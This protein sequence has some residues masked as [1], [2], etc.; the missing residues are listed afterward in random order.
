MKLEF[1]PTPEGSYI[2][3]GW[4]NEVDGTPDS[5]KHIDLV[6]FLENMG[7]DHAE[8]S[9]T[10]GELTNDM[11]VDLG[12]K[13][14]GLGFKTLTFKRS[15]GGPATRWAVLVKT[16]GDFDYYFVDLLDQLDK[17]KRSF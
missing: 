17:Y 14:I 9:A 3:R 16:E 1:K 11:L 6:L 15:K 10:K 7:D 5:G 8:V 12:I 4:Y 2:G 13:A